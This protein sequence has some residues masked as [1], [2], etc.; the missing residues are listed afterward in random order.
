MRTFATASLG[1]AALAFSGLMAQGA[2]AQEKLYGTNQDTR[3]GIALKVPEATLKKLLPAGWESNP[4]ANGANLNITMVNG[5]SS[6]D[7]EGK[8]T[9]PNTGVALTAPVK[10]TGTNETGAMVMTGL[11]MAHYAPGAYGV[12]MPAKVSIDRKLH[13]DAEGRTTAD[14]TWNLKG[15]GGNS[16]HIHVAYVRGA[17]NRGKAEAKVYSGA[18]PEFFRIY[19]IEQGT[20]VVRGGAGGDRVK[21]LSIKATGS[22][23]AS[24]LDGKEQVVAVTAI[25]WY[26][27]SVYLPAM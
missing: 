4:A 9:T 24:V 7:P 13:T 26:S 3:I 18:K 14:E 19:R 17:P 15:E 5:I 10:K 6:Q 2:L 16:L 21:A 20:D 8:P 27:R 22:K 11:F 25:P 12:F 1:A 23:L